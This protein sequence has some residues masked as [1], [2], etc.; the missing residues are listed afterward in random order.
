MRVLNWFPS[1]AVAGAI[2]YLSHQSQPPGDAVLDLVSDCLLHFCAYGILGLCLVW[3]ATDRLRRRLSGKAALLLIGTAML[4]GLSDEWHQSF[5]PER[6]SSLGD[7]VADSLGA[8]VCILAWPAYQWFRERGEF[9][10]KTQKRK[11]RQA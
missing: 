4:Y 1:I 2:F 7:W 3:G 10:A 9:R 8:A 11:E 6:T 5:I